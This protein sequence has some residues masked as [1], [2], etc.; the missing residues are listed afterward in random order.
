MI[1]A[2]RGGSE[3]LVARLAHD[4]M[5]GLLV[6]LEPERVLPVRHI[7][8]LL[9]HGYWDEVAAPPAVR[10]G[11]LRLAARYTYLLTEQVPVP[12]IFVPTQSYRDWQ[13]L[14]AQ[15]ER[16]WKAG[17][18]AMT[19]ARAWESASPGDIPPEVR[20]LLGSGGEALSNLRL[21]L[22]VPEYRVAL[23]GGER[24]SQTDL[25]V[26]ARAPHGL[27]AIAVEGKVDEPF[28]PTLGEKRRE[29]S[30]GAARRL[31]YLTSYLG[32]PAD[33]PDVIRY[34]LLHRAVSALLVAEQFDAAAAVLLVHSFS[35]GN[36]GFGDFAA[37]VALLGSQARPGELI[38]LGRFGERDLFAGWCKGDQRFRHPEEEHATLADTGAHE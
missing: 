14:L 8:S 11:V 37:F 10:A 16:H 2:Q 3:F 15:P 32:L 36:A 18:S 5:P 38:Y 28:G 23:P 4:L 24:P 1:V 19:L 26:L 35:A 6:Q 13:R 34:Q 27:V 9:K 31:E 17:Y 12:N 30:P 21:L 29:M 25:L 7:G 33:L 22:A 20:A